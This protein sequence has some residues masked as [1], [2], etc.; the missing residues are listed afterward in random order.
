MSDED[1]YSADYAI[2]S[3]VTNIVKTEYKPGSY[4]K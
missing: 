2:K 3:T 1:K 4:S